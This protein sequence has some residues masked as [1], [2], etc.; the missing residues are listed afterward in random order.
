MSTIP[1][2]TLLGVSSLYNVNIKLFES[3]SGLR[4]L[5]ICAPTG[6]TTVVTHPKA[7]PAQ[8][9]PGDFVRIPYTEGVA[10]VDETDSSDEDEPSIAYILVT[11]VTGDVFRGAWV[12]NKSE[13]I[14]RVKRIMQGYDR[15]LTTHFT[16]PEPI[17]CSEATIVD[18]IPDMFTFVVD[19]ATKTCTT[20]QATVLADIVRTTTWLHDQPPGTNVFNGPGHA[21]KFKNAYTKAAPAK[22]RD[23]MACANALYSGVPTT[24]GHEWWQ[25]PNRISAE[26]QRLEAAS[27]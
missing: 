7:A 21:A 5:E 23:I 22:Q 9:A 10:V 19:W 14:E 11:S 1:G 13:C 18:Q 2:D 24:K 3:T 16:E 12:Y 6:V 20:L 26:L 17:E 4:R 15:L 8:L 27:L 25:D